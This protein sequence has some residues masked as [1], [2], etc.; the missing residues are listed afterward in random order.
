[1]YVY[2]F[3]SQS[4][5]GTSS[6][7]WTVPLNFLH[8]N[9]QPLMFVHGGVILENLVSQYWRQDKTIPGYRGGSLSPDFARQIIQDDV[10]TKMTARWL[11][12][13]ISRDCPQSTTSLNMYINWEQ[14]VRNKTNLWANLDES[15]L[16]TAVA[17]KKKL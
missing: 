11:Q 9:H 5:D 8:W 17:C 16:L 7:L 2:V 15:C 4:M 13:K 6:K 3:T 10:S 14:L 1:M 12:H